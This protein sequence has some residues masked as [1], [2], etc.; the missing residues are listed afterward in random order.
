MTTKITRHSPEPKGPFW[1]INFLLM[2]YGKQHNTL[3]YTSQKP[4]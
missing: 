1:N 2:K 3:Q 4:K